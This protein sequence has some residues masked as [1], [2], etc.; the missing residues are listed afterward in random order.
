[1]YHLLKINDRKTK[2]KIPFVVFD[3]RS[4]LCRS[5]YIHLKQSYIKSLAFGRKRQTLQS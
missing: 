5:C 3:N 1:M 4:Q 2:M